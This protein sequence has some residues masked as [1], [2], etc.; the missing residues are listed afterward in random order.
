M[1]DLT[2]SEELR[3]NLALETDRINWHELQRFFAKGVVFYLDASCDLVDVAVN[4]AQDDQEAVQALKDTNK[5]TP[6][7]NEQAKGWYE[8]NAE[9][10]CVVIAPFLLVQDT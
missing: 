9:L 2:S 3:Q 6:V 10:L 5:L 4:I 7:S 8:Q 1:S